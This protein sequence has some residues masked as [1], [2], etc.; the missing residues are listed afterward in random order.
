MLDFATGIYGRDHVD[1]HIH[2][3]SHMYVVMIR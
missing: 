1:A 3:V 2:H